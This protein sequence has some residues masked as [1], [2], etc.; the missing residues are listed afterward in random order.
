MI[1]LGKVQVLTVVKETDFGIYVG[2]NEEKVLL[3]KKQV[4][5]GTKVGDE[6]EVFIYRD[7]KDRLIATTGKPLLAI[8]ETG[9]LRVKE[10]SRIGAFLDWGLE[11]DLFLPFKEQ[12]TKI[13]PE[14]EIL[15][16]VYADKSNRLCA[17]M[18]VYP[19]LSV[20]ATFE[21]DQAVEAIVYQIHEEFGVFA[22]IDGKYQG[23]IPKKEVHTQMAIGERI[24]ARVVGIREDGKV[25]LSTRQQA[26][27]Q[28]DE[29][30]EKILAVIEQYGGEL[31]YTDKSAP[32]VI[33]KDFAMSKAAFKRGIGRLLK[34]GKVTIT[35]TTIR[36]EE[37]PQPIKRGFKKDYKLNG[38]RYNNEKSNRNR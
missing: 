1:M 19:Y 15:V 10:I 3:P 23:M 32:E 7:S 29:D 26:Y 6:I 30:A 36:I 34:S 21:K 25:Y 2:T 35:E 17:T 5:D 28:M 11:K 18:K 14:D 31:P 33:E 22:A 8:G 20:E 24:K 4:P 16:A 27:R 13:Q 37:N 38:R 12:I 9:V